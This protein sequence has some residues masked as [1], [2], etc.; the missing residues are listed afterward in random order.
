MFVSGDIV[1]IDAVFVMSHHSLRPD[2]VVFKRM[3]PDCPG[4]SVPRFRDTTDQ[5]SVAHESD[6]LL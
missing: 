2:I 3:L 4:E 1:E 5:E 6:E